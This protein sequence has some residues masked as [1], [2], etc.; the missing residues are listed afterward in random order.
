MDVVSA[1]DSQQ[2]AMC[3]H[4]EIGKAPPRASLSL[5]RRDALKLALAAG[6]VGAPLIAGGRLMFESS[7][8]AFPNAPLYVEDENRA[9]NNAPLVLLRPQGALADGWLEILRVEGL[10]YAQALSISDATSAVLKRV[11]AAVVLPGSVSQAEAEALREFALA[12]GGLIVVLPNVALAPLCGLTWSETITHEGYLRIQPGAIGTEGIAGDA[13][14]F[15][16]PL[17]HYALYEAEAVAHLCDRDGVIVQAPAVAYR[18]LGKGAVATWC[19]DLAASVVRTRQGPMERVDVEADGLEGVRAVDRFVGFIDLDRIH[20]PQADEQQRLLVNLLNE[21]SAAPLPRLWYFPGRA[22]SALVCTGDSHNNPA[23]AVDEVLRRVEGWGGAM[24]VYYTP[25]P[26]NLVRRALRRVRDWLKAQPVLGDALPPTDVVTPY[27]A[28][29]WRDRGHEFAL[30]PYV[31]EGLEIGWER[32]WRQF[33]GLGYGEFTTTRTHRV[34]WHGWADTAR[35]QAGYGVRMNLDYYHVGPAFRRPDGSWAFGYFTGSGLPM[36]FVD[37]DGRLIDNWQQNTHLV[38]EQLIDMPWG[39]NFTGFAPE[40]AVEIVRELIRRA[41]SGAYAALGAQFHLDPFAVP[42]PWTEGAGRFLDGALAAC[43]ERGLPIL[44]GAQWL[45]FTQ[46]RTAVQLTDF[47]LLSKAGD[48][49][50]AVHADHPDIGLTLLLPVRHK[51]SYLKEL[52]ANRKLIPL[53]MRQVG[54]T[55]YAQIDLQSVATFV[56]ARYSGS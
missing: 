2:L 9:D 45:A 16:A 41:A 40:Q 8:A 3:K 25:P 30:H 37:A 19:Y 52:Q 17:R 38:D 5:T 14:Q 55:L 23:S 31:E 24:S 33:T 1:F 26:T 44:S 43:A 49:S 39:A 21:V 7:G 4:H 46:A 22:D 53:R 27:H 35:V 15:H 10:P 54:A 28:E 13:M 56:D 51:Q 42:G 36:R 12:G 20:L 32:Y 18:R 34:L 6:L 50:F 29:A 47:Q 11:A 48:C